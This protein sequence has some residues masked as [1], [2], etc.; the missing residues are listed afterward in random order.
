MSSQQ[1]LAEARELLRTGWYDE[2]L[3]R[4]DGCEEWK[5]PLNTQAIVLRAEA[6]LRR[7]PI[8]ALESLART[9]HAFESRE[10]LIDY[11]IISS[12]A[13]ANS[14][15]V[16]SAHQMLDLAEELAV[17]QPER[18]CEIAHHRVRARYI[19][20][21]YDLEDPDLAR[22]LTNRDPAARFLTLVIRSWLSAEAGDYRAQITDLRE[23]VALAREH[24]S[25][26][27]YYTLGRALYSLIRIASEL[28]DADAV[29]DADAL[30]EQIEWT[31][32]L[33]DAQF[34]CVRAFSWDAFLR[35]DSARAQ[36]LFRDSKALAPTDAWKVMAHV[37]RAYVARINRNEAWALEELAQAQELAR[38]ISWSESVGEERQVLVALAGL[39]APVDMAAAQRFV[40]TYTKIGTQSM[41]P[42]LAITHDRRG[43]AYSQYAI[44]RVH[45]VL[46]NVAAATAAYE[47]AY[48]IFEGAGH[49]FRAALAA[50]GLSEVTN[51]ETWAE[52]ARR[53]AEYFPKSAFY[54]FLTQSVSR[55]TE[56]SMDGLS[57][58]QRQL[59]LAL[60]A[61]LE[62]PALSQRFSRSEFTIKRE[63][64]TVYDRLGVQT[65][66]ALRELL[67]ERGI[68]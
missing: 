36:W 63:V 46:R 5:P 3:A 43:E 4:L 25:T 12:K 18:K 41:D 21:I 9:S 66:K 16:E 51:S 2:A 34:L 68:V 55:K 7:D 65:R 58:L 57:P 17:S 28:G 14:R 13:Y 56:L 45:Q 31:P 40:S 42:T 52:R 53:H 24:L 20:G 67:E 49:H 62:V 27:D 8:D 59:A 47:R 33:R 44:G 38:T 19:G 32:D 22:A 1:Q 39:L 64:R 37:D 26:V 35:G 30:Y 6:Q 48:D 29:D 23:C 61:G 60:C 54:Q 15:N 10:A 50:Q 11:Y